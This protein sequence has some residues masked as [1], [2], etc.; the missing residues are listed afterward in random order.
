MTPEEIR[1]LLIRIADSLD[2]MEVENVALKAIMQNAE[3]HPGEAP[4]QTQLEELIADTGP[5]NPIHARYED[6]RAEIQEA[7]VN[8]QLQQLM[9]TFPPVGE[10]N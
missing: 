10:P 8:H 6:L 5:H 4:L 9:T 1:D 7:Y 2:R 3:P